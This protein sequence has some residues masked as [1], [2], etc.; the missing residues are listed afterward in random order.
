MFG[1][2]CTP[3]TQGRVKEVLEVESMAPEEKYL[4]LPMPEG[5][6]NKG[7]FVS[8]KERLT[9]RFT[10]WAEKRMSSGAKEILI[11]SVAQ[12]IPTYAMRVFELPATLCEEMTQMIRYFW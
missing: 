12:A 3:A 10:N 5:R 9:K 4:G 2:D 1:S 8:L 7:K 11:K 6:M